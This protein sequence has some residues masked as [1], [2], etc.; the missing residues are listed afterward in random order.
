[1]NDV[2]DPPK[3]S[4]GPVRCYLCSNLIPE[5]VEDYNCYGCGEYICDRHYGNT[6]MGGHEPEDHESDEDDV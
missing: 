3:T 5:P 2:L 6:P 1:M 4:V